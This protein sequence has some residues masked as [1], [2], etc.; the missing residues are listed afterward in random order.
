M[1]HISNLLDMSCAFSLTSALKTA[2][3]TLSDPDQ[4][5]RIKLLLEEA[6]ALLE[7]NVSVIRCGLY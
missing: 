4:V 3:E 7:M 1:L 6:D 5:K 2:K